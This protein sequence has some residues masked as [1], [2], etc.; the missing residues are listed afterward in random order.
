[1]CFSRLNRSSSKTKDGTPSSSRAKPEFM[2]SRYDS[3][4]A[5]EVPTRDRGLGSVGVAQQLGNPQA[6]GVVR[7]RLSKIRTPA[8]PRNPSVSH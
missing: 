3:K 2:R 5:H 4:D 6:F 8:F 1:V 7:L